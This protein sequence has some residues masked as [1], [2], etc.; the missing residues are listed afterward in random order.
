MT[1]SIFRFSPAGIPSIATSIWMKRLR[2]SFNF[3]VVCFGT[4][5]RR[6]IRI[7]YSMIWKSSLSHLKPKNL[8]L[9][10]LCPQF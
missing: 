6:W 8:L 2:K 3:K 7:S 1:C 5:C 9:S 10:S 4:L